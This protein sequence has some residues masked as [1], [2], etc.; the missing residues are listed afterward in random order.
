MRK[1]AATWTPID[2]LELEDN[3]LDAVRQTSQNTLIVAGPGAGKTELLA[4]RASFLLETNICSNPQKILAISFKRD[5][6]Q[7]LLERVKRRCGEDLSRRFTSLTFDSFGKW[8]V[9]SFLNALPDGYRPSNDY[10]IITSTIELRDLLRMVDENYFHT[11]NQRN[12]IYSLTQNTFPLKKEY[13]H[14]DFILKTLN[15]LITNH[16]KSLLTFPIISRLAQYIIDTNPILCKYLQITYSHIFLDEFQDTTYLQYD[17]IKSCFLGSNAII[18][19]VGDD[20]Q[21]IM[22]WA[23]AMVNIFDIYKSDFNAKKYQL[24]MNFRSAPR[25]IE[26]QQFLISKL[27][28]QHIPIEF[29]KNWNI[30]DGTIELL[31]FKNHEQEA[32]ELGKIINDWL[33]NEEISP[34]DI[35]ILVKQQVDRYGLS[36]IK[37]LNQ[38]GISA[39]NENNY[40]DVLTEDIVKL[41]L[42]FLLFINDRKDDNARHE[43][44]NY[45]KSIRNISEDQDLIKLEMELFSYRQ[46]I[47]QKFLSTEIKQKEDS[48]SVIKE[49]IDYIGQDL[50]ISNFPQ[51]NNRGYF[52]DLIEKL[53][54]FLWKGYE[55]YDDWNK[56][57]NAVKGVDS[58]P[59]MT[60]HKCKGLEYDTIIFLGLEDSAFWS[61]NTQQAE[62]TRTF[63]VAMSRAKKRLIFT[64]SGERNTGRNGENIPQESENIK[65][66]YNVLNES[67]LVN[68]KIF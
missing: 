5:A 7:N 33:Q 37:A 25:L 28:G 32:L 53:V 55:I 8:L 3:A 17:L 22:G 67:N 62:D 24:L 34:R 66:F 58:I 35:C 49:L 30:N 47:Q 36:I 21:S 10:G 51:Y 39:R 54:D 14:Y 13:P 23:G 12:L 26:L 38:L 56:S 18:T 1:N 43:L 57:I 65:P 41:I 20:K 45:I 11:H 48:R 42:N 2:D 60:V 29:G 16:P 19:A 9:D 59:I 68:E 46:D 44:V 27:M 52:N 31:K 15:K 4:Q 6:A 40:Q 64:F 50:I 63:L 61:F